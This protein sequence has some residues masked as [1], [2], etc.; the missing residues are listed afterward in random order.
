[1]TNKLILAVIL[2]LNSFYG[3]AQ[4]TKAEIRTIGLTCSLCSNAINKQLKTMP[5]VLNIDIDLNTNTFIVTLKTEN[6]VGPIMFKEKVEKAGFFIGSL[7]LTAS[8][9]TIENDTY[10]KLNNKSSDA[11]ATQFQILDQGYVTEKEFKKLSKQHKSIATYGK[12]N[13]NDFHIKILN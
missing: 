3:N 1:M 12:N 9:N 10:I 13:E 11:T 4:I 8:S 6:S 2:F 5:E 7:T